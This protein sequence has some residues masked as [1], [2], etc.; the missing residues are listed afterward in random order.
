L[1]GLLRPRRHLTKLKALL[2]WALILMPPAGK[3]P[4]LMYIVATTQVVSAAIVV[5]R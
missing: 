5:E 4:L 1:R 3:E 2:T